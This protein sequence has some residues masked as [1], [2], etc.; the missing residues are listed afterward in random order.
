[1]MA[2]SEVEP[3]IVNSAHQNVDASGK[4]PKKTT[5]AATS[6]LIVANMLGAGIVDPIN[7]MLFFFSTEF[8]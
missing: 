3:L 4:A 5:W 6:A 8:L 2:N 1:M 7:L